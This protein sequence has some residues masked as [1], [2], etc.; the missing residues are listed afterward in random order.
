MVSTISSARNWCSGNAAL[1][2][3]TGAEL[4]PPVGGSFP[5]LF[6]LTGVRKPA[7]Q[8]GGCS[9]GCVSQRFMGATESGWSGAVTLI[10]RDGHRSARLAGEQT[11]GGLDAEGAFI[12][13]VPQS[14]KARLLIVRC[15]VRF[16]AARQ[17]YS[18]ANGRNEC[19][20]SQVAR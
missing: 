13:Q 12:P 8:T 3:I 9:S 2:V 11:R 1:A 20:R 15:R 7:G 19:A 6:H 4:A 16:F 5:I 10:Y 14:T 18:A 17:P